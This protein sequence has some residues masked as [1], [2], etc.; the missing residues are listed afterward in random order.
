MAFAAIRRFTDRLRRAAAEPV[1]SAAPAHP[2]TPQA[3]L[4]GAFRFS[5]G[6]HLRRQ[7]FSLLAP[8]ARVIL[9]DCSRV[10]SMDG[11]GLAVLVEFMECCRE[12]HVRL[13]LIEPS[14][15]MRDAFGLY[16]LGEAI[17]AIAETRNAEVHEGVLVILEDDFPESIRI[18]AV[19]VHAPEPQVI[20]EEEIAESIRLPAA[21]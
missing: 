13:R 7:L 21:A 9:L 19:G 14:A 16:G 10:A 8:G 2:P 12:R 11:C 18:P 17:A 3:E 15:R 20:E 4:A 1:A 6:P 5:D